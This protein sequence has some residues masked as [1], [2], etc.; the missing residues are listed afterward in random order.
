MQR[1]ATRWA[2]V[3]RP[4]GAGGLVPHAACIPQVRFMSTLALEHPLSRHRFHVIRPSHWQ[5]F[6]QQCLNH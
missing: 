5:Q 3:H 2:A 6:F 4:L 1:H